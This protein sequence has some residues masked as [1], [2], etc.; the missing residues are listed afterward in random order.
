MPFFIYINALT[1]YVGFV[2]NNIERRIFGLWIS[3]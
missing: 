3:K 2:E 1:H